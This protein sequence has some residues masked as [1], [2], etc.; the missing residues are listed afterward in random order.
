[1]SETVGRRHRRRRSPRA[2]RWVARASRPTRAPGSTPSAGRACAR[3]SC[4]VVGWRCCSRCRSWQRLPG[5]RAQP[6]PGLRGVH[7][8]VRPAGGLVGADRAGARGAV[9]DR[10]L[11]QR[12]RRIDAGVPFL[13]TIPLAGIAAAL[14]AVVIGFPAI[15][16][17]GFFLAIATLALGMAIVE[18]LTVARRAHRRRRRDER[19]R[20]SRCPASRQRLD[21]LLVLAIAAIMSFLVARRSLLRPV[22][23]HPAGRARP[24]AAGRVAR[25]LAAALPAGRVRRSPGSSRPWRAPSTHSC[26]RS[27]SRRCSR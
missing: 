8:G 4:A 18:R 6:D 9:R 22:R 7:A 10:R 23:P 13:V 12:H 17:R 5:V 27:S 3:G 20:C 24:R 21:L 14:L 26:R 25:R 11:R 19:R 2:H 15:R 1:M 16:L